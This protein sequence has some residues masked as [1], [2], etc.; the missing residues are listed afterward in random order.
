L[1]NN[2]INFE[3]LLALIGTII[4]YPDS[5]FV[6][7]LILSLRLPG[8]LMVLCISSIFFKEILGKLSLIFKIS[9]ILR[10]EVCMYDQLSLLLD[11]PIG[12]L[13]LFYNNFDFFRIS[14]LSLGGMDG[15]IPVVVTAI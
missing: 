3:L 13:P 12:F 7:I 15:R 6:V 2:N 1:L 14:L 9:L 4:Y 10:D 5:F 11:F 8:L